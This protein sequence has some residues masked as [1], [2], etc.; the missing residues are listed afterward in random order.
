M[1]QTINLFSKSN[2]QRIGQLFLTDPVNKRYNYLDTN[3]KLIGQAVITG[4][5]INIKNK[6]NQDLYQGQYS[7]GQ[8]DFR[9]MDNE[10][11]IYGL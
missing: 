2:K 5:Y 3:N 9:N 6:A 11:V 4:P 8:I 10:Y 7:E 1:K